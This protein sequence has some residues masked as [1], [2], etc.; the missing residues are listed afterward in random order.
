MVG[1]ALDDLATASAATCAG[2]GKKAVHADCQSPPVEPTC[3]C[4]VDLL[5]CGGRREDDSTDRRVWRMWR[6]FAL[7]AGA[8]VEPGAGVNSSKL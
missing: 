2:A 1:R 3:R 6:L 5:W 4:C 8:G 7:G